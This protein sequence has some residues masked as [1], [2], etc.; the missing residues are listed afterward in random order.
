MYE[1][2]QRVTPR[3]TAKIVARYVADN[4]AKS[5]IQVFFAIIS[6]KPEGVLLP[7]IGYIAL[8]GFKGYGFSAVLVVNRISILAIC[9]FSA[10]LVL[11]GYRF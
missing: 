9:D 2:L 8:C 4:V 7:Y 10:V 6:F 1:P 5:K 3:A 11:I